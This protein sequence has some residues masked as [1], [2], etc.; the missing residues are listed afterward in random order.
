MSN[1]FERK[2]KRRRGINTA[3][4]AAVVMGH[5]KKYVNL[6]VNASLSD[7]MLDLTPCARC[8]GRDF[9]L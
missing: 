4:I 1:L 8:T 7:S 3:I 5:L 9:K 6:R 2:M